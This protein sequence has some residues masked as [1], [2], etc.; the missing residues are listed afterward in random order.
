MVLLK[1]KICTHHPPAMACFSFLSGTDSSG[2]AVKE[3]G[4]QLGGESGEKGQSRV[5]LPTKDLIQ[6][7][8]GHQT[9]AVKARGG[10]A[11]PVRNLR[12]TGAQCLH[13][14]P[15]NQA[16]QNKTDTAQDEITPG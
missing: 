11:P 4:P 16:A 1:A 13:I 14:R 12:G 3:E 2:F 8:V 7:G 15:E 9:G 6:M 5:H 10:L